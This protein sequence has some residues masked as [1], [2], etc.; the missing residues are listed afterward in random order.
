M[1]IVKERFN[2]IVDEVLKNINLDGKVAIDA[3]LGNGNDSLKILKNMKS[4]YLYGF[5]IQEIAIENSEKLLS[6][7]GFENYKLILDSHENLDKYIEGEIEFAIYNLG[8]LPRA[9]KTIVTK[10]KSTVES[11]NKS[12]NKLSKTGVVIVVSYIG[13]P[14]SY[15]ENDALE[16]FLKGLSQKEYRVEKRQFFNQINTPPIVYLI[17]RM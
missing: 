16:R 11:V 7:N 6:K 14:G 8:Y 13:H 5:D 9:D 10:P 17:D 3:T 1:K 4:G 15:E 12:I 2:E